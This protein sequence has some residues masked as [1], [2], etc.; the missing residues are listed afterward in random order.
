MRQVFDCHLHIEGGMGG[1]DLP[2]VSK[3]NIIFNTVKSYEQHHALY[4]NDSSNFFSLVFDYKTNFDFVKQ[5]A[6]EARLNAI[7]IHSRLQHLRTSDYE[8]LIDHLHE[9]PSNLPII[10]DAFYFGSTL[11]FQPSLEGIIQLSSAFPERK[12]VVAHAG[13]YRVLKY[14]FHLREF[15]NVVYDLSFSLQYLKD[16]SVF[17]DLKKLIRYTD[18]RKI[19]FG[20]DFPF[21][22]ANEQY[23]IL[24]EL[25]MDL[26]VDL[27]TQEDIF[28]NN[29]LTIFNDP[30]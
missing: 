1:Y 30:I 17:I 21:G 25:L 2:N 19:M 6:K 4:R 18:K 22:N 20:S 3:R 23:V 12:V 13:G 11:E 29:A 15:N 10:V 28:Y 27:Q 5:E 8:V 26:E 14:F 9:I 24:T 7:K 16:S